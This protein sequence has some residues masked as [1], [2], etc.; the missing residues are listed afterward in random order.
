M[1]EF[2]SIRPY[3][4]DEVGAVLE[5][6]LRD[7]EFLDSIVKFKLSKPLAKLSF[8]FRSLVRSRLK[9]EVA[10]VKTVADF[11]AQIESYL[12]KALDETT[13]EMTVSGLDRLDANSA[14]LFISNHRDIAMDP[15]LVNLA[16]YR[17]GFST[18]RIA[19]GDNLLTKPFASDL[20]RLNKSFIV[21]RSATAPREKLKAAK[22]LSKYIH[23]SVIND[24]ENVW[25]AQREGRAKD[26]LDRTNSAII[27][28][29][30]Y[31]KP[32][33]QSLSDYVREARIVPVSISYE[34]DPCDADKAKELYSKDAL[35]SYEKAEHEDVESIA[36][37]ITG[38]KGRVHLA[39]GEPLSKEFEDTDAVTEE[40]DKQILE[41]YQLSP[42]NC[43]AFEA[44]E[45]RS[46]DVAVGKKQERFL[47]MNLDRERK[48][49][50]ARLESIAEQYRPYFLASY[51]NPVRDK[52]AAKE[53]EPALDAG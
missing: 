20:M 40:I 46:P 28:M 27:S 51:A 7:T 11:Q 21:N 43:F 4:D 1:S 10:K 25:I 23:H 37:G 34:Y 47:D 18:L 52:L 38:F 48:I 16:I 29:L 30:A 13:S 15:A 32:K 49:F 39:F 36:R 35:G 26:G 33:S 41:L 12:V 17:A 31:S 24:S 42:S 19:I 50:A 5:R 3:N 22:L 53:Q 44:L 14:Y 9:K 45:G 2:D 8:A 6:L